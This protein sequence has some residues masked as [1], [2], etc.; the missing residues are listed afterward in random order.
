[1]RVMSNSDYRLFRSLA[2]L[3]QESLRKNL[4]SIM[5]RKYD[6][7]HITKD[8]IYA[9][10]DIPVTLVAHMDTVFPSPPGNIYYDKEAG[11]MWSPD[12]L[13]ADDRAGVFAILKI[14]Q[15]GYKPSVIF[16]TDEEKGALGADMLSILFPEPVT[17]TKYVIQLDRRGTSDCVF[18][19]CE[20][21]EKLFPFRQNTRWRF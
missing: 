8:F 13:G 11:V 9:I 2:S 19:E 17:E 5:K 16:T 15:A 3:K 6:K 18:Y 4:I 20:N 10:G 21:D 14:I 7:I 1:M 12:G